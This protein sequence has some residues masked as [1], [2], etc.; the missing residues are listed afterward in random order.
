MRSFASCIALLLCVS[1]GPPALSCGP[2]RMKATERV[3]IDA[4]ADKVW[5]LVGA[6]EDMT[7][8]PSVGATESAQPLADAKA[9]RRYTLKSGAVIADALTA[10]DDKARTIRFLADKGDPKA[11]PVVGYASVISVT[12]QDGK[13]VVEWKGAYSRAYLN[14]DPP[15]ELNDDAATAAVTAFQHAGLEGLKRR[16]EGS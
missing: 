1:M 11:L 5:A 7:W 15:P 8:H 3:T 14:N 16:F 10:K 2:S 12:E 6:Y 4:P 13:T 9:A